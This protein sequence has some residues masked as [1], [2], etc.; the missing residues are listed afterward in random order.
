MVARGVGLLTVVA[1]MFGWMSGSQE[2]MS[3]SEIS[4]GTNS[5]LTRFESVDAVRIGNV[6]ANVKNQDLSFPEDW[7]AASELRSWNY[8]VLHHTASDEAD[9]ESI[10][11]AHLQRKD[12]NGQSWLGIGYHFVIGN[13]HKMSDGEVEVTFRW[14]EQLPGAH[15]G[16]LEFNQHGIGVVLVGNFED[17]PPTSAQLESVKRLVGFLKREHNITSDRIVGHRD[18]KATACPGRMFPLAEVAN[19][20]IE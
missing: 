6:H 11:E 20:Q 15:A 4:L 17:S 14:R 8:I 19:S 7:R 5:G 12:R 1:A 18:V 13:G 9:V 2:S 3:H 16:N 10:H